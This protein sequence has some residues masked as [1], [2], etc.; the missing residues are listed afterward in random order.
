LCFGCQPLCF[1]IMSS[2]QLNLSSLTLG[3]KE[4]LAHLEASG[5]ALCARLLSPDA[6]GV[7]PPV[8]RAAGDPAPVG[9]RS[10]LPTA[11]V[12]ASSTLGASNVHVDR[13][14]AVG[15][16]VSGEFSFSGGGSPAAYPLLL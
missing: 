10:V 7:S 9:S 3:A 8:A 5:G 2:F 14:V 16:G 6:G 15:H 12:A 11:P 4:R 1:P 13:P